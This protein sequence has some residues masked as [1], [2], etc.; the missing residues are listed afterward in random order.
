MKKPKLVLVDT[1][2]DAF[3]ATRDNDMARV[4]SKGCPACGGDCNQLLSETEVE[5]FLAELDGDVSVG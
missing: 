3:E 4:E 5:A 1:T 2:F